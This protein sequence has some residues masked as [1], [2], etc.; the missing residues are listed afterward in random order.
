MYRKARQCR[1]F[2]FLAVSD[3]S[4]HV[5]VSCA[6]WFIF[7]KFRCSGQRYKETDCEATLCTENIPSFFCIKRFTG[8]RTCRVS[9]WKDRETWGNMRLVR[10]RKIPHCGL[11]RIPASMDCPKEKAWFSPQIRDQGTLALTQQESPALRQ[12]SFLTT[13]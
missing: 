13:E 10:Y 12:K 1:A 4:C 2:L 5:C 7:R 8:G 9:L 11:Q 3:I 6:V